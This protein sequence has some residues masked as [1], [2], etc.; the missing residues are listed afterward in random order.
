M[1]GDSTVDQELERSSC[2][3]LWPGLGLDTRW[4]R[5][6]LGPSAREAI[7]QRHNVGA[8][9][10]ARTRPNLAYER[11]HAGHNRPYNPSA[12]PRPARLQLSLHADFVRYRPRPSITRV[13]HPAKYTYTEAWI[14]GN[15]SND[16]RFDVA[17]V[18]RVFFLSLSLQFFLSLPVSTPSYR[19]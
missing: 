5:S 4:L 19:S 6:A 9:N 17:D 1:D 3:N 11:P 10:P 18:A 2:G 8:I 7:R 14:R 12:C 15:V 13:H 16:T